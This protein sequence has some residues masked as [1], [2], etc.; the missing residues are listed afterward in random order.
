MSLFVISSH[1]FSFGHSIVIGCHLVIL[2]SFLIIQWSFVAIQSFIHSAIHP[3]SH[4]I[5]IRWSFI[6]MISPLV[7]RWRNGM[8]EFWS[9][10]RC[11]FT[12]DFFLFP[13]PAI[14]YARFVQPEFRIAKFISCPG[15]LVATSTAR[16]L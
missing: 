5:V 7:E 8:L 14:R 16:S 1:L 9:Y 6:V 10:S 12:F 11:F 13:S 4:L 2:L 15:V 3:F